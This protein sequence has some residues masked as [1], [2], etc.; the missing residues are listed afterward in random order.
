MRHPEHGTRRARFPTTRRQRLNRCSGPRGVVA[1]PAPGAGDRA[2]VMS[3][4]NR[5]RTNTRIGHHSRRRT[6]S[7]A[8]GDPE[9]SV[10][11]Y[12]EDSLIEVLLLCMI[13]RR[14]TVETSE[15]AGADVH[16]V[17]GFGC[18]D[19]ATAQ[20]Q[21][22]MTFTAADL[23]V[24]GAVLEYA[25]SLHSDIPGIWGYGLAF[26]GTVGS[27][28]SG[29]PMTSDTRRA[30]REG[31]V[32]AG[33]VEELEFSAVIYDAR[34][35]M[36]SATLPFITPTAPPKYTHTETASRTDEFVDA[37]HADGIDTDLWLAAL[38]LDIWRHEQL[39][40]RLLPQLS[41]KKPGRFLR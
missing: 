9:R 29:A 12:P 15:H 27:L 2:Q 32:S 36:H 18:V 39:L 31:R 25:F 41:A 24:G 22:L 30:F 7:S 4:K 20:N 1:L 37:F 28:T 33:R 10:S 8:G 38:T 40:H 35:R 26:V 13:A 17:W 23:A 19:E 21:T 11:R 16:Q 34:G 3:G 5:K 6:S 14:A